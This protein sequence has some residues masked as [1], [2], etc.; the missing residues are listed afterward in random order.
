MFVC[1]PT[2]GPVRA[3]T[4]NY[5]YIPCPRVNLKE[6]LVAEIKTKL[7]DDSKENL[8]GVRA[9]GLIIILLT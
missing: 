8:K 7:H 2:L 5:T 4:H 1:N 3:Y 6:L 9:F